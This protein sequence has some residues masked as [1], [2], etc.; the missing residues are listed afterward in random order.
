MYCSDTE[1]YDKRTLISSECVSTDG[2]E[3][4]AIITNRYSQGSLV[5]CLYNVFLLTN[6]KSVY[7]AAPV[8]E[9]Q[10]DISASGFNSTLFLNR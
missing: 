2:L 8:S 10:A 1:Q 7:P 3:K 5:D 4:S 6:G 9:Y